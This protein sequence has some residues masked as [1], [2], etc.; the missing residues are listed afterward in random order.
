MANN[1]RQET[2]KGKKRLYDKY[3]K[4]NNINHFETYK[5]IENLVTRE[6]RKSKKEVLNKLTKVLTSPNTKQKNWWKTLKHFIKPDQADAIPTLNKNDQIYT[7]EKNTFFTEQTLLDESQATLPQTVTNTTYK[8]D[9]IIVKPEEARHILKSL[10]IG[11]AD[12]P[13]LINNRLLKELAKPLVLPLFDLFNFSLCSGSMPHILKQANVTPIHKKN[14]P[15]DVSNY[16]SII[17][18]SKYSQLS[19]GKHCA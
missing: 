5:Q 2:Q 15:S 4:S 19:F 10:L 16:R 12:G 13:D 14:D 1:T 11:K 18:S 9:S 17:V 3:T 7:E 8:L 6:I